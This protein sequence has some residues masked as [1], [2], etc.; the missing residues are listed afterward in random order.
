ML[1]PKAGFHQDSLRNLYFKLCEEDTPIIKRTAAKEFGMLC[2]VMD[3]ETVSK[4][5]IYCYKKFMDD[6]VN[7]K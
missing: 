6:A 1:Y 4:E 3:R 7:L 5:M 2:T